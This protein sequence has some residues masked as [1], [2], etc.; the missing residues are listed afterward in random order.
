MLLLWSSNESGVV[1]DTCGGQSITNNNVTWS[2]KN[3]FINPEFTLYSLTD[4][5]TYDTCDICL[6]DFRYTSK[7]F[8]RDGVNPDYVIT[9]LITQETINNLQTLG[10]IMTTNGPECYEVLTYF[11]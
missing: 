9:R 2:S 3:P 10:P 8:V 1:A 5:K 4:T 11:K 7:L 6:S